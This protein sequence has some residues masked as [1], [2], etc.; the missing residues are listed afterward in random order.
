MFLAHRL[1]I[2]FMPKIKLVFFDQESL[3]RVL[4]VL[5]TGSTT[6]L[7]KTLFPAKCLGHFEFNTVLLLSSTFLEAGFFSLPGHPTGCTCRVSSSKSQGL[8]LLLSAKFFK[9]A[10]DNVKA[11][12]AKE[13][14]LTYSDFSK[15]FEI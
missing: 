2:T 4:P 12:I 10:F 6:L 13:V 7:F 14:V 9:P 8:R 3:L 5:Y 1:R 11:A 15:S